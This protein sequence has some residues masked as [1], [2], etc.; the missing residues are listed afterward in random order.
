M[1][2][3][4]PMTAT[5]AR[6]NIDAMDAETP[7]PAMRR[8]LTLALGPIGNLSPAAREIYAA[9]LAEIS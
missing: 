6:E 2:S 7:I 8:L 4:A 1:R 9:K 3:K 5:E